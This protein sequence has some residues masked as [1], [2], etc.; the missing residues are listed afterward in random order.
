MVLLTLSRQIPWNNWS[1]LKLLHTNVN[2]LINNVSANSVELLAQ[3]KMVMVLLKMSWP[4]PWNNWHKLKLLHTNVNG[5]INDV[6]ANSVEQ[7]AQIN[8]LIYD[9]DLAICIE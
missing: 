8:D 7:L 5:L 1:K 9:V 4:I 6:L 2:G 3:I